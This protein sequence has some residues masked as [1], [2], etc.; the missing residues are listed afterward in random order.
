[1]KH[2]FGA[3]VGAKVGPAVAEYAD[4]EKRVELVV[5]AELAELGLKSELA[6]D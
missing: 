2:R 4:G 3:G 6:A 1:M 5:A